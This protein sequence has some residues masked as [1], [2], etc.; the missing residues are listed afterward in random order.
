MPRGLGLL[1]HSIATQPRHRAAIMADH[2][3]VSIEQFVNGNQQAAHHAAK[4]MR[5]DRAGILDHAGIAI[6]QIHGAG[7]QLDQSR[8]HAGQDDQLFVRRK[9]GAKLLIV[10]LRDEPRVVIQ[11]F[12]QN[13]HY[14]VISWSIY[15][16]NTRSRRRKLPISTQFGRPWQGRQNSICRFPRGRH[17]ASETSA[18]VR[19]S[20]RSRTSQSCSSYRWR[21]FAPAADQLALLRT[22]LVRAIRD[23]DVQSPLIVEVDDL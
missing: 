12:G 21:S 20:P 14:A 19:S 3:N 10:A 16:C 17:S 9:V 22:Q 8:V 6:A 11:D 13:R 1:Q 23:L 15:P 4:P 5:H 18:L 2:G 7:Q